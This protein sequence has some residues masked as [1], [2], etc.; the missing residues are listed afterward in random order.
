MITARRTWTGASILALACVAAVAAGVIAHRDGR[1]A[2]VHAAPLAAD[3]PGNDDWQFKAPLVPPLS[4]PGPNSLPFDGTQSTAGATLEPGEGA[5]CASI[6]GSVWY[7]L[8]AETGG[9]VTIDTF[10]SDYDTV[11]AVYVPGIEFIPSP[12]GGGL[13]N[14]ACNDDSGGAQARVTF[15]MAQYTSYFIQVA[16]KGAGGMLRIHAECTPACPPPNDNQNMPLYAYV[17][18][19]NPLWAAR[20]DTRAAT[21]EPDE[22]RPC[23]GIGNTVWF[24]F[25]ASSAQPIDITTTGSDFDTVLAVYA[26]MDPFT[27]PSPPG[28]LENIA[29]E[30]DGGGAAALALDAKAN[31][32]YWIQAGGAA[33]ASGSLLID[34]AC[35]G[36]C[37][38]YNDQFGYTGFSTPPFV[39]GFDNS[40]ATVEPDE[41]TS[42]GDMGKTAWWGVMVEG[43]TTVTIDTTG[44]DFPTAVAVYDNPPMDF[45]LS[46]IR[47]LVCE[48]DGSGNARLQFDAAFGEYYFVQVGGV[49]GASGN[50]SVSIDCTPGPCPPY[51]D[52]IVN[53]YWA[54]VP[55]S[56]PFADFKDI[57][58]ATVEDGEPTACGGMDRTV[59]YRVH[60]P[61]NVRMAFDTDSSNFDTAIAVYR[62]PNQFTERPYDGIEQVAC[63]AGA[64]GQQARAEFDVGAGEEVF[65]QVGGRNGAGGELNVNADC[66]GACPPPNDSMTTA[67]WTYA[68]YSEYMRTGGATV[69]PGEPLPCGNI[70]KTVWYF[71]PAQDAT[72][73]TVWT[74][75]STFPTVIAVY[76][77]TSISPP[78]GMENIGCHE[79]GNGTATATWN[80]QP[81]V[82]YLVQIGGVDGVG[83]DLLMQMS[84]V[85][86]LYG[87]GGG[88][89]VPAPGGLVGPDTGNGG[90]LPGARR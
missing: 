30:D 65:V 10:G 27:L 4:P 40:G 51:G 87:H 61:G 34:I 77:Q 8:Y 7:E 75:D 28:G 86:C 67:T 81:G 26:F 71:L 60:S 15:S 78:G 50:L 22:P 57:R 1:A 52:S 25:Y 56:Y 44:S 31:T 29:C 36:P 64:T 45:V 76:A 69:E 2:P 68:P 6:A 47:E 42:C 70:G 82:G 80:A 59:W 48:T 32:Q 9:T 3:P 63:F 85:G 73:Y 11:L 54:D 20:L 90:L 49:D 19:Y 33:G 13:T 37:P 66:V 23:G 35:H 46:G 79:A 89:P 39:D 17:D 12:P 55:W 83:G 84:C 72:S 38:P 62:V 5:P 41:P 43:D 58:G 53:A 24:S 16:S 21:L 14:V 88:G 18:V 74:T